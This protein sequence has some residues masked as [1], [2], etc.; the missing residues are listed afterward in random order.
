MTKPKIKTLKEKRPLSELIDL[1]LPPE[2]IES[3]N[4]LSLDILD[5]NSTSK[6]NPLLDKLNKPG[7][8]PSASFP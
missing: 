7:N 4:K 5:D 1:Y 3:I 8:D 2:Q 6:V